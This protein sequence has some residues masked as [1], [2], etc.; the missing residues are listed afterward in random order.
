MGNHQGIEV[1]FGLKDDAQPFYSKS[2]GIP[3]SIL[4]VMK[5]EIHELVQKEVFVETDEDTEWAAPI[6][7]LTKK[8]QGVRVVSNFHI[9]N[10]QIKC[11]PWPMPTT[12]ELLHQVN[13]M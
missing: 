9:L 4:P 3:V 12:R 13:G 11:S 6:F 5:E 2:Y 7:G 8:K 1:N 10:H